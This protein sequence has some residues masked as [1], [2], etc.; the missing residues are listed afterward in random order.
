MPRGSKAPARRRERGPHDAAPGSVEST[1]VGERGERVV[2]LARSS[3]AGSIGLRE[4]QPDAHAPP[5]DH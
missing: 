4:F 2:Y 5:Y 1:I 3:D